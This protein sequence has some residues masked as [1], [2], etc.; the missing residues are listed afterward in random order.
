M[1]LGYRFIYNQNGE[2]LCRFP[3]IDQDNSSRLSADT[4]HCLDLP[5]GY[6]DWETTYVSRVDVATGNPVLLPKPNRMTAEQIRI[7]QLED[8]LL[9]QAD[10]EVGG[11]L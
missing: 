3:E 5:F 9:L 1:K 11:I 4:L 2:I 8:A 6:A 10:D 7:R